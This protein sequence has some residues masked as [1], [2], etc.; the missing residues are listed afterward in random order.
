MFPLSSSVPRLGTPI[1][2]GAILA[3]NTIL[4]FFYAGLDP[5]QVQAL[6]YHLGI[7][8]ARYTH[9]DWAA[10][11]GLSPLNVSPFLWSMFL[12]GGIVHL[13]GN[14]WTLWIFGPNVE[15]RMG[16]ARFAL[17]YLLT[18]IVAGLVHVWTNAS[19][20]VPTVGASGAIAGVMGAYLALFPRA[21]IVFMIPIFFY[22]LLFAWPAALY[23]LYWFGLQLLSGSRALLAPDQAGSIAWWAHVGGFGAGYLACRLFLCRKRSWQPAEDHPS[24]LYRGL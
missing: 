18:G 2:T 16:P 11:V 19:S 14:L 3:A 22:P 21:R 6:F 9:P 17:F 12:H 10:R 4:F 23:L 13:V 15:E 8:P 1:V 24:Y 5:H 7:V 20:A